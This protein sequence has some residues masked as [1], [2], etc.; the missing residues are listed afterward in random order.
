MEET[1]FSTFRLKRL[2]DTSKGQIPPCHLDALTFLKEE[3]KKFK[4]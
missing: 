1:G 2:L 4:F 3:A